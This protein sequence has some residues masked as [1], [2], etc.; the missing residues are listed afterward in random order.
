MTWQIASQWWQAMLVL[1][2]RHESKSTSISLLPSQ[3]Y[4]GRGKYIIMYNNPNV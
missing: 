1:W 4:P 3:S 2:E